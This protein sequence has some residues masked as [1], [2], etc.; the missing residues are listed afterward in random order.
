MIPAQASGVM[1]TLDPHEPQMNTIMINALWGLGKYA[2]EGTVNPDLY[3]VEKRDGYPLLQ[4]KIAHKPVALTVLPDG[5]CQEQTLSPEQADKA[6]LGPDQIRTLAEIGLALEKHF[7]GPQDVEWAEDQEGAIII[8]QSRP[9]RVD[10]SPVHKSQT[11]GMET[12]SVPEASPVAGRRCA[13]C[14]R[15]CF[16]SGLSAS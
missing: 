7:G 1:F 5:G 8:L 13:G 15:R 12:Q 2:V 9:L 11:G 16:R 3:V 4:E 6:C 10:S 14:G